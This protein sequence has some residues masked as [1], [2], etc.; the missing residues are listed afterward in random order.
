MPAGTVAESVD[1]TAD[2]VVLGTSVEGRE[3]TA[4]RY[5]TPGGRRVLVIGVIHGNEDGG[6]PIVDDLRRRAVAEELSPDVELW[7][8]PSM[9]PDGQFAQIRQNANQVDLNRN[10]P[11]RWGPIGAPGDS[12]Y[13]GA[14]PASEPETRAMVSFMEQLR[15]DL[16][17]WYHQ[18]ANLIIPSNG[19]DGRIRA[20]YAELSG[21]PVEDCCAGGVYTGVAATWARELTSDQDGAAFIVELPGG[22]LPDDQVT[23]HAD[24]VATII[25]ELAT[26]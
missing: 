18:D 5:G 26:I 23:R 12:Q 24:T 21:L 20:R 8:V 17:L 14:G 1:L 15:P 3:I 6:V 4:E 11:L 25:S 9:N 19:R 10:F 16:A 22:D 2:V 13:A 7:L